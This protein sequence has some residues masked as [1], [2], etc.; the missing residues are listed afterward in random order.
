MDVAASSPGLDL[1]QAISPRRQSNLGKAIGGAATMVTR[2]P[3]IVAT[4]FKI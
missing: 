2:W 4:A 1:D 3:I